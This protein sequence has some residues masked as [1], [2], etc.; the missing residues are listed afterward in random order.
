MGEEDDLGRH[1]KDRL[2]STVQELNDL[3]HAA[4]GD[5]IFKI[6]HTIFR[7]IRSYNYNV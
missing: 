4:T 7:M 6:K 1:H 2:Y 3:Q 5:Y